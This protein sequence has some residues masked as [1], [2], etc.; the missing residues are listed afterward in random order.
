MIYKL[1][2]HAEG[3]ELVDVLTDEQYENLSYEQYGCIYANQE[4]FD[5]L[6]PNAIIDRQG[7]LVRVKRKK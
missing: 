3:L 1:K 5:K 6:D 4:N 7:L 2:P